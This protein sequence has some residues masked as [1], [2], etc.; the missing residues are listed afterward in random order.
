MKRKIVL[1]TGNLNKVDEIKNILKE[2]PIE[3]I[4]KNEI[5]LKDLKIIEDGRTLEE[6]SIKK[7]KAL[8]DKIDYMVMADDSGLFVDVLDGEPGVYSSRYGGEEGNDNKNNEKLLKELKNTSLG[9]RTGSFRTV[10]TLIKEDKEVI[11]VEGECK[12]HIAFEKKGKGGFGYD[13]LFMPEGY[14]KSFAELGEEE[15][16]KISH[17]AKA[18]EKFKKILVELIEDEKN[19]NINNI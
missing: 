12:G 4:S 17:R 1:S 10:I 2:L 16:N 11:T 14:D 19:E 8:S 5:N 3:V 7:A 15:K 13:P 6:N 18:L 9:N